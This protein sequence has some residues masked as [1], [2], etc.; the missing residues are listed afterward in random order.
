MPNH[1]DRRAPLDKDYQFPTPTETC[2]RLCTAPMTT[3][4]H[5]YINAEGELVC[6][7]P[8]QVV[9]PKFRGVLAGVIASPLVW[10]DGPTPRQTAILT[11]IVVPDPVS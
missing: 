8:M 5:G 3:G 11:D 6:E 2:C 7:L 9:R 10:P 4:R 1:Q